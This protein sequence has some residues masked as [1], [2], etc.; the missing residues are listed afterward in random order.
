MLDS[1]KSR[2]L[3][4]VYQVVSPMGGALC[5]FTIEGFGRRKLML[6]SAAGNAICMAL[7]AGLGSQ[8]QNT[9]AM[10]GAVVFMFIYHFTF[11]MGLG[12]VPFIYMAE[13]APLTLRATING[14][15]IGV[16]WAFAFLLGEVS[17]IAFEAIGWR[18]FLIFAGLNL[19]MMVLI[20]LLFP[21]TAG[22]SLEEVDRIFISSSSIWDSVWVAKRQTRSTPN[23]GN[24]GLEK[25]DA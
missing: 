9:M 8:P 16:F 21:E 14:I 22:R 12:S 19:V 11:V 15:S 4:A 1:V 3:A 25:I 23:L 17:P 24:T 13:I 5:F 20:Y 2:I 7:V 18:Y 6:A 10:H